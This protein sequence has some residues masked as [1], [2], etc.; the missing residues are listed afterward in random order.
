[1]ILIAV[2]HWIG[3]T[4][5][6][7]PSKTPP[8]ASDITSSAADTAATITWTTD[9]YAMSQIEYGTSTDYGMLTPIDSLLALEHRIV[10]SGLE[11]RQTYHYRVIAEDGWQNRTVSEDYTFTTTDTAPPKISQ[12]TISVT[13]STAIITWV[14]DEPATSQIEY[15]TST[16]Y[17]MSTA[18]DSAMVMEHPVTLFGLERG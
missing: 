2:L 17:G 15:G 11:R 7:E 9:Q 6:V 1:M 4:T 5:L 8:V 12:V 3:C 16:G 14:T 13:D 18:M 10:L